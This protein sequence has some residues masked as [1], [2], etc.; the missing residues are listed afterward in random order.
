M[1]KIP[2]IDLIKSE[3]KTSKCPIVLAAMVAGL[4]HTVLIGIVNEASQS[5][6]TDSRLNTLLFIWFLLAMAVFI[7]TQTYASTKAVQVIEGGLHCI[8]LRISNKIRQAELSFVEK[9]NKGEIYLNLTKDGNLISSSSTILVTAAQGVIVTLF[10]FMYIAWLSPLAFFI[11]S[12]LTTLL[13][14][15]HFTR[16]RL[17]QDDIKEAD[18]HEIY[19]FGLL[20]HVLMGI[21]EIKL[22]DRKNN[23][24]FACIKKV[25]KASERTK[26][27]VGDKFV[28]HVFAT[29]F[30]QALLLGSIVFILSRFSSGHREIIT[31]LIAITLF[32]SG[33]INI[34][35]YSVLFFMQVNESIR[36]IQ[37]L[38][39]DLDRAH[40]PVKKINLK[41]MKKL[42]NFRT[43]DLADV[44]YIY[45]DDEG[46]PIFPLGP[47]RLSIKR[48]EMVFMVGGNGSG[49]TTLLKLLSGLYFPHEGKIN[50]D[51]Q[52]LAIQDYAGYRNLFAAVFSDFHLF[53]QLYG[54][55][56]LE[57]QHVDDWLKRMQLEEK[58]SY[59]DGRFSTLNLSTGQ[60]KRLAFIAAM[61]E[62]R[63]I[64]IFDELAADQDP[65]FRAVFYNQVLPDLKRRGKTVI[66]VSHDDR[67]WHIADR[68]VK[69]E[70]GKRVT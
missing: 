43:I 7:C 13:A 32:V 23:D 48:G 53:D 42:Y 67:F 11:L 6:L 2:I 15:Y 31:P 55:D 17:I 3:T 35:L 14:I 21:K 58:T 10:T 5:F 39:D 44:E 18:Q 70:Y 40:C 27:Q 41:K 47:I 50:I 19:F 16:T 59:E 52:A 30:M 49:K 38:E 64:C 68:V 36:N 9:K 65:E 25:S 61:L 29:S 45:R 46:C 34:I 66:A 37:R 24:L 54:L 57:D 12:A 51:G 69:F 28:F 8:R 1:K 33:Y 22:N 62:D 60:R 4:V 20:N 56:E 63:P 26:V